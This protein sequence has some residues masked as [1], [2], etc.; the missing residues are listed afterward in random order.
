MEQALLEL[1]GKI[2]ALVPHIWA[3][4]VRQA[5]VDALRQ[6]IAAAVCLAAACWV[7]RR[8]SLLI[9]REAYKLYEPDGVRIGGAA[10]TATL[11]VAGFLFAYCALG[12]L[13]NPQW[14]A[15]QYL[16]GLLP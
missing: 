12:R 16:R 13:L 14:Y 11:I 7:A 2:E 10:L 1:I 8:V 3:L 5:L 6:G 15:I 4:V 9:A